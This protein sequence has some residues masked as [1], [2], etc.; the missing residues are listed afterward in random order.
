MGVIIY[1]GDKVSVPFSSDSL[2][3]AYIRKDMA[4]D[5]I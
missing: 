2:D 4:E 5:F 1:E 3:L